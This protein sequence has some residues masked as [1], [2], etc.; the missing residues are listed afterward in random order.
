MKAILGDN[1]KNIKLIID[2]YT[3]QYSE[4]DDSKLD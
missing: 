3:D 2:D 1:L 4:V